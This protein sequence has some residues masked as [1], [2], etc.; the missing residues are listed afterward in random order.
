MA[1]SSSPTATAA[2]GSIATTRTPTGRAASAVPATA[3]PRSSTRTASGT[4]TAPAASR[5]LPSPTAS[6]ASLKYF[7]PDGQYLSTVEGFLLPCHFDLRGDVML[8]PD[9]SSPRHAARQGQQTARPPGQ[10]PRVAEAGRRGK[11]PHEARDVGGRQVRPPAR[12]LL[13]PR[14]QHHRHRMGRTR[15]RRQAHAADVDRS[16][17]PAKLAAVRTQFS[18]GCP[19]APAP[20]GSRPK[21][22][23]LR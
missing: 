1:T 13:R 3:T 9:L 22:L 14:R 15:P 2:S 7:T 20:F 19:A 17:A 8:V 6:A 11:A 10:L 21:S 4:T 23:Q 5:P 18:C 16:S 12:R